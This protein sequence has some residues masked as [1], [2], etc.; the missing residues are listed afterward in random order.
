[1][2]AD[3]DFYFY[4]GSDNNYNQ[5]ASMGRVTDNYKMRG[6]EKF[7]NQ[8][9]YAS[10]GGWHCLALLKSNQVISWGYNLGAL[11][12]LKLTIDGR[13]GY[14][15]GQNVHIPGVVPIKDTIIAVSGGEWH[16]LALSARGEVY[17]WGLGSCMALGKSSQ[18]TVVTPAK[19]KRLHSIVKLCT[20]PLNTGN[21][22]I[23]ASGR[24]ML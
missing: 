23:N 19:I 9:V 21:V 20:T 6:M 10:S 11:L 13:C 3:K 22:A 15:T 7:K 5:A 18:D 4:K 8:I 17:S 24:Y 16:T 2:V 12:T 1:M 14:T